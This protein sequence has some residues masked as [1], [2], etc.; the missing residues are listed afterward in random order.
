MARLKKATVST[1][2][3]KD[4]LVISKNH[5]FVIFDSLSIKKNSNGKDYIATPFGAVYMSLDKL[6]T[7]TIYKVVEFEP[8]QGS[9]RGALACNETSRMEKLVYLSQEF[10]NQDLDKI[11]TLFGL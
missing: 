8:Q 10:P 5:G 9:D 3:K 4:K 7:N 1:G 6:K 2:A 11:A